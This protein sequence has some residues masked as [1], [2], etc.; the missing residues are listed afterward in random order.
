MNQRACFQKRPNSVLGPGVCERVRVK[1]RRTR[2]PWPHG[3]LDL[4]LRRP[5]GGLQ[6]KAVF[7]GP[8][9]KGY[10]QSLQFSYIVLCYHSVVILATHQVLESELKES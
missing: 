10:M 5:L 3:L 8:Q 9:G 2:Q 1:R 7:T 4:A 6:A